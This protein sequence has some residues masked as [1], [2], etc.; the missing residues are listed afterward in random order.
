[1]FSQDAP[2]R[3]GERGRVRQSIQT[4][5]LHLNGGR[6]ASVPEAV[7]KQEGEIRFPWRLLFFPARGGI[8]SEEVKKAGE[9]GW[10]RSG[11]G[12]RA[13]PAPTGPGTQTPV[14][15]AAAGS[16][17]SISVGHTSCSASYRAGGLLG[18]Q[19]A[20]SGEGSGRVGRARPAGP[21][22]GCACAASPP[23]PTVRTTSR[24]TDDS[25]PCSSPPQASSS[26]V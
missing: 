16:S 14:S 2:S 15:P 3:S 20:A 11:A 8:F 6:G 5:P 19:T 7:L 21:P 17:P 25:S 18:H 12:G 10:T 23:A 9:R 13:R 24:G 4:P 26:E 22:H 1:M